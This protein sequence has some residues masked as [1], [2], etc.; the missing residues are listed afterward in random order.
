MECLRTG[1]KTAWIPV[2]GTDTDMTLGAVTLDLVF[3]LERWSTPCPINMACKGILDVV[4]F[5]G[6]G[7]DVHP[8][9]GT[10]CY[11]HIQLSTPTSKMCSQ[12][13][14]LTNRDMGTGWIPPYDYTEEHY[15]GI[16]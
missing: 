3:V 4:L 7:L 8:S 6:I 14:G 2:F 16:V 1:K 12:A 15:H 10:N 13:L 11:K 5:K 9:E